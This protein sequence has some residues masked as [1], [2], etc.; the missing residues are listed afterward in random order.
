MRKV[1]FLQPVTTGT[2]DVAASRCGAMLLAAAL[3]ALS[4]MPAAAQ[5]TV[6]SPAGPSV[7]VD[8]SVLDE[9]GPPPNLASRLR[10]RLTIPQESPWGPRRPR[11]PNVGGPAATQPAARPMLTPP[12]QP[13]TATRPARPRPP[14]VTRTPPPSP[15][16][17][18]P[19]REAA[20]S[21]TPPRPRPERLARR[22]APP[23]PTTAPKA[24]PMPA[25]PEPAP[26]PVAN[27]PPPPAVAELPPPPAITDLPPPPPLPEAPST[28]AVP[29]APAPPPPVAAEPE[30][31]PPPAARPPKRPSET[32]ALSSQGPAPEVGDSVRILFEAGTAKLDKTATDSMDRVASVLKS[33]DS[34]RIQLLAYAGSATG[35]ASQ[36][37]RLSLSRALA[38]RS[39][40]IGQGVRSTRIDVRALGNKT[41]SGPPDRVDLMVVRR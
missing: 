9:L 33:D 15:A 19:R 20:K 14:E 29:S 4:A 24:P 21:P 5:Q 6:G 18:P 30:P 8:Y 22:S 40:L 41:S 39:Y 31:P 1:V 37:R 34:T 11:F 3:A 27:L 28:S 38:A 13:R 7:T 36:A 16:A 23:P 26:P 17:A 25:A 2:K 35:S 12:G 10:N 32:A